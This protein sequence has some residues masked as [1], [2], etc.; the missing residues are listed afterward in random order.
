MDDPLPQPAP[1]SKIELRNSTLEGAGRGVFARVTLA[2]GE[3]VESCPVITLPDKQDRT[4]LRKTGLVNYYFLWGKERTHA[5]ICLGFG[6]LY[7]HSYDPNCY[8][9]KRIDEEQMDFYTLRDITEGEELT[10]NYNGVPSDTKTLWIRSIPPANAAM[11]DSANPQATLFDLL[12]F[13][14]SMNTLVR[15][16]IIVGAV[17]LIPLVM[18]IKDGGV[19]GV[20]WNWTL[21]DFVVM[22]GLL[23]VT[24]L[25]IDFAIRKVKEPLHR[26][27]AV[28]LIAL[29][30]L[31]LWAELAVGAIEQLITLL[32]G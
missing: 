12:R 15:I 22:G 6:S 14:T 20:G 4:R 28:A 17:L 8:Y 1:S 18:T 25:M 11:S 2:K 3:L 26:V 27:I 19:E 16:A 21:S 7:N 24:S 30:F 5:A 10:V 23:F 13:Y 32:L 31:A 9:T 29:A